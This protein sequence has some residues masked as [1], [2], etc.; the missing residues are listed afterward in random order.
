MV[1]H[2]ELGLYVEE[3]AKQIVIVMIGSIPFKIQPNFDPVLADVWVTLIREGYD[4]EDVHYVFT[5][6]VKRASLMV[7]ELFNQFNKAMEAA[8]NAESRTDTN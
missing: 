5:E 6:A 4:G 7:E 2:S 3:Y 1:D 8:K